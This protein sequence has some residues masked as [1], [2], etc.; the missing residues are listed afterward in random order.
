MEG[1]QYQHEFTKATLDQVAK[2]HWTVEDL[3]QTKAGREQDGDTD[4]ELYRSI[5]E[6]LAILEQQS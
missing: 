3:K 6:A 2:G 4:N 5:S 1:Q